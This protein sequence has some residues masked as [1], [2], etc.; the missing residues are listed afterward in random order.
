M[1]LAWQFFSAVRY[2]KYLWHPYP[3]L[4]HER[5]CKRAQHAFGH[6]AEAVLVQ[7]TYQCVVCLQKGNKGREAGHGQT[8]PDM[9]GAAGGW[10]TYSVPWCQHVSTWKKARNASTDSFIFQSCNGRRIQMPED[11]LAADFA[12]GDTS[13]RLNVFIPHTVLIQPCSFWG[14]LRYCKRLTPQRIAKLRC[15]LATRP[16]NLVPHIEPASGTLK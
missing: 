7:P 10:L 8:W 9:A 15:R 2:C 12:G 11:L 5:I 6:D 1:F 13:S 16:E 14:I 4:N 3:P